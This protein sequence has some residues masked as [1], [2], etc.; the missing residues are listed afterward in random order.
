MQQRRLRLGDILDDYCPRERR[1]TNHAVV[2]M[3][4]DQI[5]QTRC[6]TCDAEHPYKAAQVPRR[7][8]KD[9][10]AVL[11][12]EVLEGADDGAATDGVRLST[13]TGN[14]PPNGEDVTEPG[15]GGAAEEAGSPEAVVVETAS[16][17]PV[18]GG[19]EGPV[20]RPLIRATLPRSEGQVPARPN[21]EFTVRQSGNRNGNF[22]RGDATGG[23]R[24]GRADRG[25]GPG[26]APHGDARN[27]RAP[28]YQAGNRRPF[29][30][31][32]QRSGH[33]KRHGKKR[34]R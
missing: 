12:E 23:R 30:P 25:R 2:A 11:P 28:H 1:I 6:T 14:P 20:H 4:D 27:S 10:P 19:T 17:N 16:N 21:P 33:A 31:G 7:R 34:S 18:P 26:G 5:R 24:G 9:A 29:P 8:K 32:P 3:I 22:V 15:E 13:R